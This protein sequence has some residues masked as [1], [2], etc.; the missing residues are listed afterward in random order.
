MNALSSPQPL[1]VASSRM[2]VIDVDGDDEE[3]ETE[4]SKCSVNENEF[5]RAASV[6][7]REKA[8]TALKYDALRERTS[9]LNRKT[10]E[11][12]AFA[13]IR[14]DEPIEEEDV[15]YDAFEFLPTQHDVTLEEVSDEEEDDEIRDLRS[16]H[17]NRAPDQVGQWMEPLEPDG[18]SFSTFVPNTR[19]PH[20]TTT[21]P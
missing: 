11:S 14:A 12:S 4:E 5:A 20:N 13:S 19:Y 16:A 2:I 6:A 18:M 1:R 17:R 8:R 15:F 9:R 3:E 7:T 21:W 10:T